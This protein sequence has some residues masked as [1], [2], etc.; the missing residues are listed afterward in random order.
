MVRIQGSAILELEGGRLGPPM[1]QFIGKPTRAHADAGKALPDT[2]DRSNGSDKSEKSNQY[3][4]Y[5][6][7]YK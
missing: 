7:T 5:S 1:H 6:N 2:S 4:V 3:P